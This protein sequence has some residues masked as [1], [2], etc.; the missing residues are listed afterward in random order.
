[1]TARE[2]LVGR[3]FGRW[4]ALSYAG[5]RKWLCRCDC[6]TEKDV[7]TGSLTHGKSAGCIKCNPGL[8]HRKTHGAKR[9]RLYTIWSGMKRRCENANDEAYSNYGGRGIAIC[10]EWRTD[11]VAFQTWAWAAGYRSTL[12][13]DR[14]N[15]D[16]NYEPGNCRWA[17]YQAQG[18]NRRGNVR[19][20]WDG[21]T[22]TLVELSERTG[23]SYDLLK[24]RLHR[25]W[26]VGRAVSEPSR[27]LTF[28]VARGNVDG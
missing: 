22:I 4:T 12:T 25:G 20:D 27:A 26:E 17:T 6:G 18:R 16:G 10:A 24:Q 13:I 28:T 11:F 8:G 19:V 15:N 2:N 5:D 1:M 9:T 21:E 3:R 23:V 14:E 7:F